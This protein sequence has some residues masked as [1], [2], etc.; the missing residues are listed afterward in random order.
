MTSA[1]INTTAAL[2][3]RRHVALH[4]AHRWFAFLEAPG[5]DLETHLK[6]FHPQVRLSGHR[7]GHLFARDH[8]SLMAWFAAVPDAISAHHIMHSVYADADDGSGLLDMVVAYQA[9]GDTGVHGAIISYAKRIEFAP[10]GARFVAL[11]KTPILPNGRPDYATSWATNRALARVHAELGRITDADSPLR[12][13]LGGHVAQVF[14]HAAA[15]EASPAY[16]AVITGSG[17]DSPNIRVL[18]LGL[19]DDIREPLP[20]IAH[21]APCAPT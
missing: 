19:V 10:D 16:E 20:I 12:A 8:D 5:G 2:A 11:D 15:P 9:P 18:R 21:M 7:G 3:T 1:P 4:L 13:A 17:C 6:I 14:A